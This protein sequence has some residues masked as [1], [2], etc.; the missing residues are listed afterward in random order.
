MYLHLLDSP[1]VAAHVDGVH[2]RKGTA[3]TE[4]EA[5]K[6]PDHRARSKSHLLSLATQRGR[7]FRVLD[8]IPEGNLRL[9]SLFPV[10]R[11]S[12]KCVPSAYSVHETNGKPCTLQ[13]NEQQEQQP[14]A[15]VPRRPVD[16]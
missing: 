13:L 15:P 10:S 5:Q 16:S 2:H 4:G 9:L 8:V 6:E 11:Q 7:L 12:A 3:H 14:G 1:A